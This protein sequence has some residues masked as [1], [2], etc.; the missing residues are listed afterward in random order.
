VPL[1]ELLITIFL[2]DTLVLMS[3]FPISRLHRVR[4]VAAADYWLKNPIVA[5]FALSI[6]GIIPV[7]RGKSKEQ[8]EADKRHGIDMLDPIYQ[9]LE[10]DGIV[11]LF[12]EGTRSGAPEKLKQLKKGISF[13]VEKYPSVPVTPVMFYG[14]GKILPK[15][16]F[17]PVPF[18]IDA[19]VGD[20]LRWGGDRDAFMG[21]LLHSFEKLQED[22]KFPDWE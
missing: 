2:T 8:I 12:P 13:I 22:G 3:S 6:V 14:L 20:P 17:I 15:G 19:L 1:E 11:I 9:W 7:E 18:F 16:T 4:P 5:W 10:Q 21:D